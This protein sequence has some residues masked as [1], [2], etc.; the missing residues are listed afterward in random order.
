VERQIVIFN[1][2]GESYGIE[3]ATV[4]NIIELQPITHVPYAPDFVRGLIN[5]RGAVL[6]VLDLRQRFGLSKEQTAKEIRIVVVEVD[7]Q[8]VG[9]LVDAVTEVLRIDEAAIEP[10]SPVTATVDSDF[11]TGIAKQD[12]QLVIL[13]DLQRVIASNN[14]VTAGNNDQKERGGQDAA[15]Q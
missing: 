4:R 6:P 11:I 10:P 2:D 5:L 7:G 12:E 13:L 14:P 1:L 3:I 15:T 8:S 9:M